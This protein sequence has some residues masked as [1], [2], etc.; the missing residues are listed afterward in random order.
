MTR[1]EVMLVASRIG[2]SARPQRVFREAS[3]T[4]LAFITIPLHM[5]GHLIKE[6]LAK[7]ADREE[8]EKIL[9]IAGDNVVDLLSTILYVERVYSHYGRPRLMLLEFEEDYEEMGEKWVVIGLILRDCKYREW[10]MI[11][12]NVK[13]WMRERGLKELAGKVLI[14]CAQGLKEMLS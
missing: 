7:Y 3:I 9:E 4:S 1:G 2:D 10:N 8:L 12:Q 14:V 5:A 11:E 13:T 6:M